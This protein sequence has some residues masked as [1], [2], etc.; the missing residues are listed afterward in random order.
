MQ[1][2]K[3][4][5]GFTLIELMIVVA[6]VAILAAIAYPSYVTHVTK[7]RR[8]AGA[9]CL[10]EAAQFMERYYTTHLT[11]DG[12]AVDFPNTQ[13]MNDLADH[14]DIELN[15][16]PGPTSY[17]VQAVPKNA[18]QQRD[19]KCGTLTLNQAGTKEVDGS[20]SVA[21]CW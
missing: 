3:Y 16:A 15:G 8:A 4:G 9:A 10:L 21:E 17:T 6:I 19:T 13:C 14:Y 20:G 18:Q 2:S 11:Y 12:A 1:K 5:K 7:T